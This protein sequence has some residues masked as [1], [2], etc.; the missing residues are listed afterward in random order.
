MQVKK[1]RMWD[2]WCPSFPS[3][4]QYVS[5]SLWRNSKG[6][7]HFRGLSWFV[8][9]PLH[10]LTD[11]TV[12]AAVASLHAD[13]YIQPVAEYAYAKINYFLKLIDFYPFKATWWIAVN[14]A[15]S[16]TDES[17]FMHGPSV[18]FRWAGRT[19]MCIFSRAGLAL[20][21]RVLVVLCQLCFFCL[22][23]PPVPFT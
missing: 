19:L 16:T 20:D 15:S 11:Q 23:W 14:T 5:F 4:V 2:I 6:K 7:K 10:T 18:A 9:A 1:L 22:L 21:T 13:G 3:K 8:R 12:G 17:F